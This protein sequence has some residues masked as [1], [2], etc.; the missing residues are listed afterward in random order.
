MCSIIDA[1][2][3]P[4]TVPALAALVEHLHQA[5]T[6]VPAALASDPTLLASVPDD[7]LEALALELHAAHDAVEAAA[8][9]VTGRVDQQIG[10]VQGLLIGGRFPSTRR[11]LESEAGLSPQAAKAMVG[12]GRD[13]VSHSTRVADAWLAGGIPGGAVRHLTI[14]V[15]DVIRRSK[16]KDTAAARTKA[17][18]TLLPIA[19]QR[20]VRKVGKAM[21]MAKQ[22]IDQDGCTE[23]ALHAFEQQH[24]SVLEQGGMVHISGTLPLDAGTA[25]LT[26]LHQRARVIAAEQFADVVHDSD[27]DTSS[28]PDADCSCGAVDRARR[29]S[30]TTLSHLVARAFGE[31]MRD[32]L[33]NG[34]VG[35]H[36]R[37]APHITVVTDLTDSTKPMF[38]QLTVP[39]SDHDAVIAEASVRR[40][41]CDADITRVVTTLTRP[42]PTCAT[43]DEAFTAALVDAVRAE[44]RSILYV[45]RAERT[46]SARLRRA[47]E[48]RDRHCAFPGCHAHVRRCHAHHVLP[49][50][51]G[52]ATDLPNMALMCV[53]HHHAVHEGGWTLRPRAGATGHEQNSWE[54]EPPPL[55]RRRLQP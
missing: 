35:S 36:H 22:V 2:P 45:G 25:A 33:D 41:L 7:V 34:S 5:A 3:T 21:G 43:E 26:V 49:W 4:V 15:T 27:C 42:A 24:L 6:A 1:T 28:Q 16:V 14:G 51:D 20:D 44:A 13:L 8:T 11:W 31:V 40:L 17:L 50:E 30:G 37:V 12:R 53:A 39:G 18:D 9:V 19:K 55:H 29:A 46:V 47:L 54:F 38:G 48:V 23:D 10:S 32:L 52:G